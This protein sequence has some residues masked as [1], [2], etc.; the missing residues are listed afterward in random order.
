M[1]EFGPNVRSIFRG[2]RGG[3]L[4]LDGCYVRYDDYS[5]FNETLDVQDTTVCETQDF[6]GNHTV[7]AANVKVLVRNLSVEAPKNDN[8]FVGFVNEGYITVYGLAQCWESVSG[9]ACEDCLAK[10]VSNIGSC[11]PK[12][13]GRVLNAGCY[14]RYSTQKFYYNSSDLVGG[15]NHGEFCFFFLTSIDSVWICNF[16]F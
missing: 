2:R 4:F 6:V 10:A 7:F 8:F 13:E 3:R 15:H 9:S 11:T 5:F 14:M 16:I 12:E 1:Q